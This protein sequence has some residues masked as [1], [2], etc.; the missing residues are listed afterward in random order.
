[1]KNISEFHGQ[2]LLDY[3]GSLWKTDEFKQAHKDQ[4]SEVFKVIKEACRYP[5]WFYEM[6]DPIERTQFSSWWRHIQIRHYDIPAVTDLYYYHELCHISKHYSNH[7]DYVSPSTW[8]ENVFKEELF[9]SME[10][11]VFVYWYM[12]T[13]R[14][15]TFSF[16]IWADRFPI[17]PNDAVKT[18]G[19]KWSAMNERERIFKDPDFSDPI[20]MGIHKYYAQNLV[21][22]NYWKEK[23]NEINWNVSKLKFHCFDNEYPQSTIADFENYIANNTTEGVA[24]RRET[25]LFHEYTKGSIITIFKG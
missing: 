17:P 4:N 19:A 1:M 6:S 8:Q 18:Y 7:M 9:A 13:L 21:W 3:I 22:C 12:H 14:D 24:F 23:Y 10:S 20:E 15:K 2:P 11:E 5:L 25:K 16:E